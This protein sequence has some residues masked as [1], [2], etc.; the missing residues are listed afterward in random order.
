MKYQNIGWTV[1]R[2]LFGLFF[3]YSP[4][5]VIVM[6]GGQQPPEAIAAAGH[7]TKALDATGFMN[8][9]LIVSFLVAGVALLFNRTA[10][11]GLIIVAPSIFVITCFHWFLTGQYVWGSI[12]PV[13]FLLLAWRYRR[14]FARLWER[15][16]A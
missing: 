16:P 12:W 4:I 3:I 7:F 15:P 6:F 13:W 1:L 10:P 11:I 14:I 5:M 8:P 9:A 2:I